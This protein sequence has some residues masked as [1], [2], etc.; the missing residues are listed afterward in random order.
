MKKFLI[1]ITL[2]VII[3]SAPIGDKSDSLAGEKKCYVDVKNKV[4]RCR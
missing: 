4:L 1:A 3:A 2:S